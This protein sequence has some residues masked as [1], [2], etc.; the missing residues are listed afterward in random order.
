MQ[1][2]YYEDV[3]SEEILGKSVEGDLKYLLD[4]CKNDLK[5]FD[6]ELITKAFYWC[7]DG[8]NNKD[9]KSGKP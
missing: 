7:V 4:S 3:K 1:F 9:R 2:N 8:H 6:R 5:H